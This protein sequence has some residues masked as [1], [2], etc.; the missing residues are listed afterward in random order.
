MLTR[1]LLISDFRKILDDCGQLITINDIEL[2]AIVKDEGE[3][4]L[5]ESDARQDL[6][7]SVAI[8]ELQFVFDDFAQLPRIGSDLTIDGEPWTVSNRW[9]LGRGT[10]LKLQ[11]YQERV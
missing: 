8:M 3:Q 1:E 5:G 11:V 9:K 2:L 7:Q 6:M 10:R 4:M